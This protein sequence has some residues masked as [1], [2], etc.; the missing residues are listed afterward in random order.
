[1]AAPNNGDLAAPAQ[2]YVGK[3]EVGGG[4][5]PIQR[6]QAPYLR[7]DRDRPLGAEGV[8]L[9]P[10]RKQNQKTPPPNTRDPANPG[11]PIRQKGK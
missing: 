11:R 8:D 2:K 10:E 6:W 5:V 7:S 1:M 9:H 3:V 4:P